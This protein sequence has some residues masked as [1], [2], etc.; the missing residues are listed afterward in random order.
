MANS[1]KEGAVVK[2]KKLGVIDH[3][4]IIVYEWDGLYVIHNTPG[5][6]VVREPLSVFAKSASLELAQEYQ[7]MIPGWMIANNARSSLG[8]EWSLFYNCQHFV[9]ESIGLQKG[10]PQLQAAICIGLLCLV[11]V[12]ISS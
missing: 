11:G 12:K 8:K 3:T 5:R 1:F 7:P 6:G 9:S 2:R 10:S 4:G